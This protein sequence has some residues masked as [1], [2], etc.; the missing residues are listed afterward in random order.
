MKKNLQSLVED[1]ITTNPCADSY[2]IIT[3]FYE[4]GF[5]DGRESVFEEERIRRQKESELPPYYGN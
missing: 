1:Y 2:E 4:V 5:N 3:H